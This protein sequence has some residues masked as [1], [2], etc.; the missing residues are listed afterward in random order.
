M[1]VIILLPLI[2]K[3]VT[4]ENAINFSR[5][6]GV[7][8][9]I[10]GTAGLLLA[11]FQIFLNVQLNIFFLFYSLFSVGLFS[12]CIYTGLKC[13]NATSLGLTLTFY[14]QIVQFILFTLFGFTYLYNAGL[15]LYIGV[16]TTNEVTFLYQFKLPS[17]GFG[18]SDP[19]KV[20]LLI[21]L[22]PISIAFFA[23]FIKKEINNYS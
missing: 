22:V 14:N 20:V 1:A 12:F 16:D 2:L 18:K 7:Y 4:R 8:Q 5:L 13:F 21:N 9:L 19:D 6:L 17:F 11:L 3:I 10:G 23:D 15:G